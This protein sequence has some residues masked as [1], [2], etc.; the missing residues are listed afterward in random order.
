M[1]VRM[2]AATFASEAS[3]VGAAAR[4]VSQATTS[5]AS[6]LNGCSG[7]AGIDPMAEE[8]ANG[9]PEQ[10]GYDASTTAMLQG[11][12]TL[13]QAVASLEAQVIGLAAAYRAM[14]LAGADGGANPYLGMSATTIS[15]SVPHAASALGDEQ[16][17]T[18][19]GEIMEWIENFLKDTAGIV[20]PTAD[21]G[22]V[23]NAASA[24][25]TFSGDITSASSTLSAAL[26]AT[27]ASEFPQSGDVSAVKSKLVELLDGF[28][29]DADAISQGC[30]DYAT[31][32][33]TIRG[34]LRA[35]LG[36]LA[37][38]VAIDIGIG[39]ALSFF[40]FGAGALA[41]V[42]KAAATVA[43][44]IPKLLSVIN[45]LKTLIQ[46]S[47]RLMALMRRA[48]IEA[49]ES[50]VSG[51]IANA[52]AS[53]AFG[54]FSWSGLGGAALSSGI[55]GVVSGPF[56]HIGSTITSRGPRM[57]V[58]GSV[59]AVTG[60]GGGIAGEWAA[61]QVTGQEFNLL[62]SALVGA[63]G[64]AAGGSLG[65]IATPGSSTAPNVE[66]S[67]P[68]TT[69]ATANVGAGGT[70]ASNATTTT[71][72]DG[73]SNGAPTPVA[74]GGGGTATP[75]TGGAGGPGGSG[76][77]SST[78]PAGVGGASGG[79]GSTSTAS[80]VPIVD[81]NVDVP[82]SLDIDEPS[83]T[84]GGGSTTPTADSTPPS[85]ADMP[86]NT[87]DTDAPSAADIDRQFDEL[88]ADI[89]R[90][91]DELEA[92]V[93]RQFDELAADIDRRFDDLQSQLES[94]EP[95]A[96]GGGPT[97]FDDGLMAGRP[98]GVDSPAFFDDG[99]PEAGA[100][101]D[102]VDGPDAADGADRGDVGD[103]DPGADTSGEG[104]PPGE[105]GGDASDA[106]ALPPGEYSWVHHPAS[107][108]PI[109]TELAD[110][111]DGNAA[112][113]DGW[114]RVSDADRVESVP[115][116]GPR[117][118]PGLLD[119]RFAPEVDV[120]GHAVELGDAARLLDADPTAP[121]GHRPDGSR[122]TDGA[123][124]S[125]DNVDRVHGSTYGT[126]HWAPN[127]GAVFGTR[128]RF[129]DL[130]SFNRVAGNLHIDRLGRTS[131]SYMGLGGGTFAERGLP[132]NQVG[133]DQFWHVRVRP[134][135]ELPPGWSIEVSRIAQAYGQPGGGLQLVVRDAGGEGVT[136]DRLNKILD[137]DAHEFGDGGSAAS[138]TGAQDLSDAPA[139]SATDDG[140]AD[141][142][143][144]ASGDHGVDPVTPE[145]GS[146]DT[147]ASDDLA[148]AIALRDLG[149]AV[150]G[151]DGIPAIHAGDLP[152]DLQRAII[153]REYP[154]LLGINSTRFG[155][156]VPGFGVNCTRCVVATDR[157]FDGHATSA[158]P[159]HTTSGAPISD[160]TRALGVNTT[161]QPTP[162]YRAI[163]DTMAALPEGS[164]GVVF[165]GRA[166]GS[167]HVFNV[168]HDRNGVVFL[169]AQTGR[170][171]R[172]EVVP[173]MY[174]LITKGA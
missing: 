6:S 120:N 89:D 147:P 111:L 166:D 121:Y 154:G 16:R 142:V 31:N 71:T 158:L 106:D 5:L 160:I 128:V 37:L 24:W 9:T 73:P 105:S 39:V 96:N 70:S 108:A 146:D 38:E 27:L 139:P 51:T 149:T 53:L 49:I 35:M 118:D 66:V 115:Y 64:G 159:V 101:A 15:G 134:D 88:E 52:G 59:G 129:T 42:A 173:R 86:P 81:S 7:M 50:T 47:K 122:Y 80:P 58:T 172:L 112:A 150:P 19:Q 93:D 104:T 72:S 152:V 60:A 46:S 140:N 97:A 40:S 167:G 109:R 141:P 151:G 130:D 113:G 171:A 79:S 145:A 161:F 132:P 170:F 18:P 92:D 32:V 21:T 110:I 164:R 29:T 135:A 85:H 44:W 143:A 76:A 1:L 94:G 162:S 153:R 133:Q 157:L 136:L 41:G 144:P 138:G 20:I 30:T 156:G 57:V 2:D 54:N 102:T 74:T 91:F 22:K 43:R 148:S 126:M 23:S 99:I 137:W 95:G 10:G 107:L 90:Q 127:D 45:R 28:S 25:S 4:K 14:E 169:D 33:E 100:P 13:A 48:A 61:S 119:G 78:A 65:N 11:G 83:T 163:T 124:W 75:G 117:P 56:S 69:P 174:L 155:D 36:Q 3:Q 17:G 98:D 87:P 125:R 77:P 8:F 34:E 168:V 84:P 123:D 131:G 68:N 62:V 12:K 116:P 67:A 55:G 63:G 114:Y 82:A 26:P 165:I 103:G